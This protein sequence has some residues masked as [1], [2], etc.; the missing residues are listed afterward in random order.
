LEGFLSE[1]LRRKIIIKSIGESDGNQTKEDD[2]YNRVDILVEA[3]NKELVII[4]L[5][6]YSQDDYFHRM[7][8]GVSKSIS[9]HIHKGDAYD[10]VRKVYSIN[11]VYFDL[12]VGKDYVYHGITNF[13]GLHTHDEL[14]LDEKQR[15]IYGKSHVGDLYPEYYI[16]KVGNFDDVA[17]DTLDE[18]IYYLKYS[19]IKDDFT[20][21]GLD[22]ARE[23]LAFDN[24]TEE[25]KKRYWRSIEETRIKDSEIKTAFTDGEIKGH[26]E[27]R[28][29][30]EAIGL[31]KGE[32]KKAITVALKALEMGMSV[33]D[34]SKLSGLS[35]QQ[36]E[37]ICQTV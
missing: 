10:K 11:I 17:K 13:T 12:G 25:E 19:K 32:H 28:V 27:G 36:I 3:D 21:Q 30:G 9:E 8:Y 26:A 18:W 5:Q 23:V 16:L 2:K 20:A 35:K 15:S 7:L 34:A 6:F 37:E 31:E 4:E 24:L 14:Q 29:E 1:L 22:Q 33:E